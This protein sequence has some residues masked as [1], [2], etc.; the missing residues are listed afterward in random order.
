MHYGEPI[1]LRIVEAL[2][3]PYNAKLYGP[4][5]PPACALDASTCVSV[6]YQRKLSETK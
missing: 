3:K 5:I 6:S 4:I 2:N 1:P